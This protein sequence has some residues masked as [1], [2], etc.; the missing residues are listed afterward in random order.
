ML[1]NPTLC[2]CCGEN[3][4]ERVLYDWDLRLS[5]GPQD[6]VSVMAYRCSHGHLFLIPCG[7]VTTQPSGDEILV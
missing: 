5:A 6:V 4:P 7:V 2:P 3:S 1:V